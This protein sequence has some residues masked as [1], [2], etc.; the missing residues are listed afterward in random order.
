MAVDRPE[1]G[2]NLTRHTTLSFPNNSRRIYAASRIVLF[3]YFCQ[4]EFPSSKQ[5]V[6]KRKWEIASRIEQKDFSAVVP[7]QHGSCMILLRYEQPTPAKGRPSVEED[8]TAARRWTGVNGQGG[9]S[10]RSL[11]LHTATTSCKGWKGCPTAGQPVREYIFVDCP[12]KRGWS[13]VDDLYRAPRHRLV[14]D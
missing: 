2:H 4:K 6:S 12:R 14:Q 9:A 3:C 5:K 13:R 11:V 7:P 1:N 10:L 8:P